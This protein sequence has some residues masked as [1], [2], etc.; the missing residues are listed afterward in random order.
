VPGK[1]VY[2]NP[3]HNLAVVQYDPKLIGKTPVKAVSFSPTELKS[4]DGV[5]VIG[6][7]PDGNLSSLDTRI[8]SLDPVLFPLSRTLRFRDT[9][10]EVLSLVNAP[11]N[12]T[13]VMLDKTGRVAA[14]WVSFVFDDGNRSQEVQRGIPADVVE[15]M[16]HR[17]ETG[18]ELRTLDAELYPMPMSQARKL[19][20]PDA[21]A[22]KLG[23]ASPEKREVL[24]VAR[25]TADTPAEKVLQTGDV[26]LAVDGKP[27]ATF[28]QMEKDTTQKDV[29]LTILRDG[30]V[31]DIKTS[32]VSLP[33]DGTERIL[34]WAGALLQKPHHAAAAQREVPSDGVLVGFYNFGSPAS[35]YGLVAG[36][37]IVGVN[38]TATPDMDSFIKAVQG[39]KDRDAVRLAVKNWEGTG[40]VI[41]LKLDQK[42]WPT[43]EVIHTDQ[44]W[45]R[46]AL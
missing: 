15:D 4:G 39:L 8:A 17:V 32:T 40:Q 31:Q 3:L 14:L 27:V 41:T 19:G 25:L 44:G 10:L 30:T 35:R 20:L 46:Q 5:K 42:Y 28:R 13:G 24:A 36:W 34:L 2:V 1:V 43:Y 22:T 11:D 23:T 12:L 7:Q 16:V 18:G 38:G 6:Y 29:D 26:L 45:Q 21:W 37:R 33:S 9:N